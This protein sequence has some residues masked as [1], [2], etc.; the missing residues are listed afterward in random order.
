M[1]SVNKENI[2]TY[3][4]KTLSMM[5]LVLA[6]ITMMGKGQI[7]HIMSAVTDYSPALLID[8]DYSQYFCRFHA[9]Y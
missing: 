9:G 7:F 8:I 2:Y 5:Q 1:M 3:V 4:G 6:F